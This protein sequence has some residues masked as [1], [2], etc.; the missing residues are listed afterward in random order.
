MSQHMADIDL[1]SIEMD[2]GN[3]SILVPT[4]VENDQ[5]S[6]IIRAIFPVSENKARY[7]PVGANIRLTVFF[8]YNILDLYVDGQDK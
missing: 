3:Q 5:F 4:D 8:G 1:A 6:N 2:W 7:Y